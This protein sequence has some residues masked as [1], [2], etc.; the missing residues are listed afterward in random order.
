M[1]MEKKNLP[2]A[3]APSPALSRRFSSFRCL[4]VPSSSR[5]CW[6]SRDWCSSARVV[7]FVYKTIPFGRAVFLAYVRGVVGLVCVGWRS[8]F[9]L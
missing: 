6:A 5:R 3:G 8:Q 4:E 9:R 1:R 7:R 2:G